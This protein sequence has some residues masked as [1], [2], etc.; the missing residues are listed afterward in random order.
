MAARLDV[1][2]RQSVVTRPIID[3]GGGRVV[4]LDDSVLSE[5]SGT[6]GFGIYVFLARAIDGDLDSNLPAI[7]VFAVH[8]GDSLLLEFF[9]AK[10]NEAKSTTFARLVASLEFLNHEAGNWTKS[11]LRGGWLIGREELFEL[12][13]NV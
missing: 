13:W 11:D 4:R 8:I 3:L 6:S 10:R 2:G 1:R 9:R 12:E 5:W 7:D